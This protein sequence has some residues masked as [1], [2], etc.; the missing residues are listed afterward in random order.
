MFLE[1]DRNLSNHL[2]RASHPH[3]SDTEAGT[4]SC[5]RRRCNTC[6]YVCTDKNLCVVG[7]NGSYSVKEHFTC[8]SKNVV[9]AIICQNCNLVYVG[10]TQ[11]RLA[12]RIT[13]HIRSIN[14]N[15]NGFP[16][17]KH[18]NPPS[19]CSI[20]DFSVTGLV[21]CNGSLRERLE[22]EHRLIYRL[23]TLNPGGL[24]TKFDFFQ[25]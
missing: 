13:E 6:K 21:L 7:P 17:A 18:F 8:I 22:A 10:E 15:Q 2:V 3:T 12:D 5:K 4:F 20:N 14:L 25:F 19:Q 11:R 9:Y 1:R 23:G 16:V 24:N